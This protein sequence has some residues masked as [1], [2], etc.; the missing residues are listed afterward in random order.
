[1]FAVPILPLLLASSRFWLRF[2][3]CRFDGL[4]EADVPLLSGFAEIATV[5]GFPFKSD[6]FG[7]LFFASVFG[8]R[9]VF[10]AS[11]FVPN[12]LALFPLR[13]SCT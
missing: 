11:D 4:L 12:E 7:T 6:A 3:S 5:N 2:E 9:E 1:M 8:E 13:R 10:L